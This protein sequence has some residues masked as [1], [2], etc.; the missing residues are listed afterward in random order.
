MGLYYYKA[1][2]YDPYIGRFLQTD[3]IGYEDQI[4]LYAYVGNDPM[5]FTD[6]TGLYRRG[7][8]WSDEEW[9]EFESHR[10]QIANDFSSAASALGNLADELAAGGDLS[11]AAQAVQ[12][13]VSDVMGTELSAGDPKTIAENFSK[14]ASAMNDSS[15]VAH[16]GGFS[17]G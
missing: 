4:N 10:D 12:S 2:M 1:R 5:N 15:Y 17:A 14:A 8:G 9:V 3:P 6:P 16:R 11:A 13:V 7:D